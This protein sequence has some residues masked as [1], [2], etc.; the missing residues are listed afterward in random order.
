MTKNV[1]FIFFIILSAFLFLLTI[2]FIQCT[3]PGLTQSEDEQIIK[4]NKSE[5]QV[6]SSTAQFGFNLINE[7]NKSQSDK[8]IFVSPLSVSTAFGMLLNGADSE[9][10]DEIKTVLGL[11]GLGLEEINSSY[12]S[13]YGLL[14][15]IDSDVNFKSANSIW[16]RNGFEVEDEF[17]NVNKQYF[18]AEVREVDFSSSDAPDIINNWVE[19]ST[20]SKIEKIIESIN[21]E[22]VM[23]LLNAI[24]FKGTWKYRFEKENT[25]DEIFYAPGG[26]EITCDLMKQKNKFDYLQ[27]DEYQ[28]VNLE[29]GNGNYKM[30]VLLPG[31]N[32]TVD[33]LLQN[34]TEDMFIQIR[35]NMAEQEGTLLLPK[36]KLEYEI[37]LNEILAVMGM[38]SVFDW[39]KANL[40]NINKNGDLYVSEAKHKTFVDVNE[41]GTEA[42][43][44]TS[45]EIKEFSAPTGFLMKVN[46]PF[47]FVIYEGNSNSIL[48]IGKINN[49]SEN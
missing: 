23:Y 13:L 38:P 41:E 30:L 24:Y 18:D 44:V 22:V 15:G 36:F 1:S 21:P 35:E 4:L 7:I 31:N 20:E 40:S 14:T 42:A 12:Q 2:T 27:N 9:T 10:Y 16:Y 49:P 33:E 47:V 34:L 11:N 37:K 46:R 5:E 8:N 39:T 17:I 19:E 29:Y 28:A 25:S 43:A 26:G 3:S 6:V 45:I 48:F 32:N